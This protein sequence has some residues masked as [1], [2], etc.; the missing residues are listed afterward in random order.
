MIIV[1]LKRKKI[2]NE[3]SCHV[4]V[5]MLRELGEFL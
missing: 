2:L 4:P 3:V 1:I 5:E